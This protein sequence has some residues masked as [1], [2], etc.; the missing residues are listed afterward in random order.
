MERRRDIVHFLGVET[1]GSAALAAF[2]AWSAILDLDAELRGVDLP[3]GATDDDY[4]AFVERVRQTR[5]AV[6]T[7]HKASL[8][9]GA[10]GLFEEVGEDATHCR[11]ISVIRRSGGRLFAE[12]I[13]VRSITSALPEVLPD[14]LAPD[15]DVVCL[16]AGGTAFRSIATFN[17][18]EDFHTD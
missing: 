16:G 8:F 7:A 2:P 13:D 1:A 12:A 15:A 14:G 11:E 17:S 6:V 4:R 18:G 3:L 10:G 5:G 9:R